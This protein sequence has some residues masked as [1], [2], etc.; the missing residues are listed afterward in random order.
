M[1]VRSLVRPSPVFCI[2][3]VITREHT[4]YSLEIKATC[5]CIWVKN[6]W[7]TQK[8]VLL[9]EQH[10]LFIY[11]SAGSIISARCVQQTV[12]F[13]IAQFI[14]KACC[15]VNLHAMDS[16]PTFFVL[17]L[18]ATLY[19]VYGTK[20]DFFSFQASQNASTEHSPPQ[21]N[22]PGANF[23]PTT[24]IWIISHSSLSGLSSRMIALMPSWAIAKPLVPPALLLLRRPWA[25]IFR[26][27]RC[28]HR[29]I[30]GARPLAQEQRWVCFFAERFAGCGDFIYENAGE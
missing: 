30:G 16:E 3:D 29:R 10:A 17:N 12:H 15:I 21:P 25:E 8:S 20:K 5:L 2:G 13:P 18:R 9:S 6:Q 27:S 28:D 14:Q 19:R 22:H 26:Q 7:F 4:R 1:N 24:K 11:W 23:T